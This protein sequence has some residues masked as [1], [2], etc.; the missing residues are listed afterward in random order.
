M[1]TENLLTRARQLV[2]SYTARLTAP[3]KHMFIKVIADGKTVYLGTR[4]KD[5]RKIA[6]WHKLRG[7][8]VTV[9]KI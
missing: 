2:R 8:K 1:G 4:P 6:E 7:Q 3:E 5:A 9:Q